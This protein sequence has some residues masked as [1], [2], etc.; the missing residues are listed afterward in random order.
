[1]SRTLRRSAQY[2]SEKKAETSPISFPEHSGAV[3]FS[4]GVQCQPD[5]YME[6][7]PQP[8]MRQDELSLE[9]DREVE[10]INSNVIQSDGNDDLGTFQKRSRQEDEE[11]LLNER[12]NHR[13]NFEIRNGSGSVS[14]PYPWITHNGGQPVQS[15]SPLLIAPGMSNPHTSS[16]LASPVISQR[17]FE[18]TLPLDYTHQ[19]SPRMSS[20]KQLDEDYSGDHHRTRHKRAYE[21]VKLN[22]LADVVIKA[23][24]LS[25]PSD[26]IKMTPEDGIILD[27][28]KHVSFTELSIDGKI[29]GVSADKMPVVYLF[30]RRPSAIDQVFT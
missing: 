6:D 21:D 9:A 11:E 7:I 29:T 19:N 12:Y 27:A 22:P 16:P 10:L 13:L 20:T 23:V 3:S 17:G 26:A 14:T 4:I 24:D 30:I 1:M 5:F 28:S 2:N 8:I 25:L 18:D 15:I